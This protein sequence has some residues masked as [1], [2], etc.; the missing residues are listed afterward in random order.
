[1]TRRDGT[2][3]AGRSGAWH[4]SV[5]GSRKTAETTQNVEGA[6]KAGVFNRYGRNEVVEVK[7]IPVP[8][9]GRDDVLGKVHAASVNPADWKVREGQ[10]RIFTGL[11]FPK[12][13]G[14]E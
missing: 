5:K 6:M 11:K 2:A 13:L 4:R 7:D 8:V 1:M 3:G 9:P 10:A 14:C 12:V